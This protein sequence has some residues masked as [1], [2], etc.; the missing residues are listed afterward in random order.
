MDYT[1]NNIAI[2]SSETNRVLQH[3]PNITDILFIRPTFSTDIA[4][5]TTATE[6]FQRF[7]GERVNLE[8]HQLIWLGADVDTLSM[9][10]GELRKIIDYMELFDNIDKCLHYIERTQDTKTFLVLS[11]K[12]D[13]LFISRLNKYENILSVYLYC[14]NE[15]YD[16]QWASNCLKVCV[17]KEDINR[18]MIS[19]SAYS[20]SINI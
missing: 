17:V 11:G 2:T 10:V 12:L 1:S 16:Q 8:S 7:N 5:K 18:L 19:L 9:T 15:D 13:E 6:P 3:S 20:C 14:R 4:S